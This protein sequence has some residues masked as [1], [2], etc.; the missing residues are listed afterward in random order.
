MSN[1]EKMDFISWIAVSRLRY[2]LY[3]HSGVFF[4]IGEKTL[5]NRQLHPD[6]GNP[7]PFPIAIDP[8][9]VFRVKLAARCNEVF[10]YRLCA[11]FRSKYTDL[12]SL[13][14]WEMPAFETSF[15]GRA[16]KEPIELQLKSAV[17]N[18]Q[19]KALPWQL[20]GEL[21]WTIQNLDIASERAYI[22]T[23]VEIYVFPPN[24]PAY[25]NKAGIPLALLRL[26]DYLPRWMEMKEWQDVTASIRDLKRRH[27]RPDTALRRLG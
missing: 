10:T 26:N 17:I 1:A 6:F 13:R 21:E 18:G 5:Y 12:V 2:P 24:L 27:P 7:P 3:D 25:L 22:I 11:K 23:P 9:V 20:R 4:D 19:P 15:D 14:F 16:A 8:S